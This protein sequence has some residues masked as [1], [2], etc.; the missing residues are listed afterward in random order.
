MNEFDIKPAKR[1]NVPV[2]VGIV[3]ASGSGKTYSALTMAR[4]LAGPDGKV[5]LIDTD[6][7][8]SLEYAE[9]F[10]G[11]DH[12]DLKPPFTPDRFIS[13]LRAFEAKGGYDVIVV[14]TI[15]HVW[16]GEG[17]AQ[18]IAEASGAQ[19]LQKW[20]KPKTDHQRMVNAFFQAPFHMVFCLRSKDAYSQ[21][22]KNIEYLGAKPVC[23]KT[24]AFEMRVL[25][26]LGVDHTPIIPPRNGRVEAGQKIAPG[27]PYLKAPDE[28]RKK[29]FVP[30]QPITAETGRIIREWASGGEG[31]TFDQIALEREAREAAMMG[32]KSLSAFYVT[33]TIAKKKH[34]A[35]IGAELRAL[36]DQSDREEALAQERMEKSR[37]DQI[38]FGLG[39]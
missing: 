10:G 25:C 19:G 22:G 7:G 20:N 28:I 27:L 6:R 16:A 12:L 30:G 14:D 26:F 37:A 4:G 17:G 9:R 11:W 8:R 15:S 1:L 33:C 13:A 18:D 38:N 32:G 23:E 5:G 21:V 29:I 34:L 2:A 31:E 3:G 24:L 35:S 36:A 39:E